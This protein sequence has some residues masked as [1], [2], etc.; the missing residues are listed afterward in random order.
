MRI[1][2][3]DTSDPIRNDGDIINRSMY[4]GS[5][6][7]CN[8]AVG[9]HKFFWRVKIMYHSH[10]KMRRVHVWAHVQKILMSENFRSKNLMIFKK[11]L[12]YRLS[13]DHC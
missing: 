4:D 10:V 13:K 2:F 8:D 6:Y 1:A 5:R 12:K 9:C 11:I 7:F 3:D